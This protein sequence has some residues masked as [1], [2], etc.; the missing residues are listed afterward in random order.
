MGF[1]GHGG[2]I[3][4]TGVEKK[5]VVKSAENGDFC[6]KKKEKRDAGGGS[7]AK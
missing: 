3:D 7:A 5:T 2:M 4:S 6:K 1:F